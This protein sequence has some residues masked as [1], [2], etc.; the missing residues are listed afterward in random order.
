[1][2]PG[3][4]RA[5]GAGTVLPDTSVTREGLQNVGP[6]LGLCLVLS[7][8]FLL[9]ERVGWEEGLVLD[10]REARQHRG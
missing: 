5:S 8:P 3:M 1:M 9:R 6:E 7:Q 10:A 2:G 4:R